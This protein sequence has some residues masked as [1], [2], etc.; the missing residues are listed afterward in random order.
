MDEVQGSV[1]Q[2]IVTLTSSLNLLRLDSRIHRIFVEIEREAFH[3]F[4]TKN[5][6]VFQTV[7]FEILTKH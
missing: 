3:I 5:I 6:G 4:S 2:S 7:T 1:V